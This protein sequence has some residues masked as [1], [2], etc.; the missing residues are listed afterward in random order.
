[1]GKSAHDAF[2]E[3][4]EVYQ[5]ADAALGFS[6]SRTCFEGP[7]EALKLTAT[8][9]PAILTT[10]LALLA[11]LRKLLPE[12]AAPGAVACAAGHSLGEFRIHNRSHG[13]PGREE[14]NRAQNQDDQKGLKHLPK[15]LLWFFLGCGALAG[16]LMFVEHV[17]AAF[18]PKRRCTQSNR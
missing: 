8:T 14:E 18:R 10:S 17:F 11:A 12:H 1:M 3:A 16:I 15:R 2:A 7:E 13:G 4:R 9:Q 6:L 5:R